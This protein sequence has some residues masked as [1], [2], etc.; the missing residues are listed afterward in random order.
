MQSDHFNFRRG[1]EEVVQRAA[2]GVVCLQGQEEVLQGT[3]R[4]K[5]PRGMYSRL[6]STIATAV[7][8]ILALMQHNYL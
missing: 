8:N 3:L 7:L 5:N 1:A 2:D 4:G 6:C